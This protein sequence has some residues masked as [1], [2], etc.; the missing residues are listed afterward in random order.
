MSVTDAWKAYKHH[1]PNK[2]KDKTVTVKKYAN[3]IALSFLNNNY[4]TISSDDSHLYI[5]TVN[6][7]LTC[8][9]SQESMSGVTETTLSVA[10]HS[11]QATVPHERARP[12]K[13]TKIL[14]R[15]GERNKGN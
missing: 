5:P 7:V 15:S 13:N 6:S 2:A 9:A 1:L 8:T 4:S 11:T 12:T 3:I 10:T 14:T